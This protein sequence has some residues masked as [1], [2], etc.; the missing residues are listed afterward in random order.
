[1]DRDL[2]E[3]TNAT[4]LVSE[5]NRGESFTQFETEVTEFNRFAFLK[6]LLEQY[7]HMRVC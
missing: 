2:V 5:I 3:V 6:Y 4:I 1:M 7:V